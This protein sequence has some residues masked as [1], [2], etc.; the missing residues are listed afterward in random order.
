VHCD[1]ALTI[2]VAGAQLIET[3]VIV[4]DVNC[5]TTAAVPDFVVSCVLVAVT[6][7]VAADAGAVKSPLELIMPPLAD[8]ITAEL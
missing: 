2:T 3:D 7:T 4:G 6:V 1:V 8:H 5:T